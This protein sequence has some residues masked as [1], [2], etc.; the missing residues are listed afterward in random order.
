MNDTSVSPPL[1][2]SRNSRFT[3]NTKVA[4]ILERMMIDELDWSL[5]YENYYQICEPI[6]CTHM[7]ITRKDSLY[8]LTTFFG[9]IGG[10]V[11]ALRIGGGWLVILLDYLRK[12]RTGN[13]RNSSH[14]F[15][16]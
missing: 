8:I 14:S 9:L 6:E 12:R 4:E 16:Q 5:N 13:I 15:N 11:T 3:P 1:N 10:L 2:A 7:I